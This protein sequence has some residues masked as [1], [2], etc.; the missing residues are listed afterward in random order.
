M[1]GVPLGVSRWRSAGTD[2][3]S[4]GEKLERETGVVLPS[5][6]AQVEFVY[7]VADV[8]KKRVLGEHDRCRN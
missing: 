8:A 5:T 3:T 2:H 6:N 4:I 1:S 7:R